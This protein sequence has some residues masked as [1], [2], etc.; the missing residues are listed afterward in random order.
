M[1]DDGDVRCWGC[2]ILKNWDVGIL[3]DVGDMGCSGYGMF[4]MWNVC[5]LGCS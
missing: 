3:W 4:R 5:A 1:W 2:G